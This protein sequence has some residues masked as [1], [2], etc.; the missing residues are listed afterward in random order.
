MGVRVLTHPF[1]PSRH[2]ADAEDAATVDAAKAAEERLP[3]VW[4]GVAARSERRW[5]GMK[6]ERPDDSPAWTPRGVR[7]REC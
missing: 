2:R 1:V 4:C 5:D 3:R 7:A 6:R